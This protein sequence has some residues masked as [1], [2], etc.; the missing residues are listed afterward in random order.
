MPKL[1]ADQLQNRLRFDFKIAMGL[2]NRIVSV[3]AYADRSDLL[4]CRHGI[5]DDKLAAQA[6]LYLAKFRIKSLVGVGLYHDDFQMVISLLDGG[7]Y[8]F[9]PPITHVI[10]KPLPWSPHFA[11]SATLPV[12]IGEFWGDARGRA[13]VGHLII[14]L[15][16]L[17]NWDEQAREE[18]YGGYNPQAVRYWKR[19]LNCEPITA[20]LPY[21]S[22]P[23]E[24]THDVS[25]A[26]RPMF[27]ACAA[28][29][30]LHSSL[31]SSNRFRP[32]SQG[33]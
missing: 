33:Y 31:S 20:G 7:N 9:T 25:S 12:C 3:E 17:L 14:H 18:T 32:A 1:T 28:G 21:P 2:A 23:S 8:P 29:S 5:T 4:K 11:P 13:T 16:H 27:T 22:L 30:A 26:P 19:K 24:L 15:C 10:S 6:H